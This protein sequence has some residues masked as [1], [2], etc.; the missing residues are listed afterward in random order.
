MTRAARQAAKRVSYVTG[1]RADY[2]IVRR[3]LHLL[4]GEPGVGL[5]MLVTGALL[6]DAYGHQVDLI[7]QDGF[8]IGAEVPIPIE[9]TA[10]TGALHA[11][12]RALDGFADCLAQKRPDLLVMLGD[13]YEVLPA[14]IAAAMQRI[15]ILHIHGGE[16]TYANYDEFIRHSITKMS[17]WHFTAAQEYRRR[18]IQLGESPD[19]VFCLGS[20]GAENALLSDEGSASEEVRALPDKGYFVVLFHPETISGADAVS[21][22]GQILSAARRFPEAG[23]VFLG[24][25]ADTG[26]GALRAA[27]RDFVDTTPRARYFEN[28][29]TNDYH[30]L[31]RHAVALVGNS[32]SG[33]IE[34]PS[35]GARTVNVGHR[36]DGRVRGASVIDVECAAEEIADAMALAASLPRERSLENPY[37]QPNAAEGYLRKTLEILA[38]PAPSG[39]KAFYDVPFALDGVRDDG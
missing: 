3:Y 36:Q 27:V 25:N 38:A 4:D 28:L 5:S 1:S 16:A 18:V 12:A 6:D 10:A 24:S 7:V 30:C 17:T 9:T 20:L 8:R 32:S 35:L 31:L 22:L 33:L 11:M 15:P 29:S 2:G 34:A 23:L 21:Q 19:R 26:S 14:A 37:Y 13:R 39:A